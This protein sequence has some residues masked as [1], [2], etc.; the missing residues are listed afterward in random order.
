[1]VVVEVAKKLE[2]NPRSAREAR[3]FVE[4]TLHTWECHH[5]L[6]VATLLTSELVTNGVLHARS[7][8]ELRLHLN[9]PTVRIEVRDEGAGTP[10]RREVDLDS[11]NG[12][13]LALVESL[14][15]R[16]GVSP[17]PSGKAVWFELAS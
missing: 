11:T 7:E 6:D 4:Q 15:R 14:S 8:I 10:V 3:R 2:A 1:M 5:L 12:R 13:G 9:G 17:A 16:W